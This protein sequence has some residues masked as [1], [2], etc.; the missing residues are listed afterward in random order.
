MTEEGGEGNTLKTV[1]GVSPPWGKNRA[2]EAMYHSIPGVGLR[3]YIA[4]AVVDAHGGTIGLDE[5]ST[6]GSVFSFSVPNN[7]SDEN[8]DES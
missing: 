5:R 6:G 8:H 3:L 1:V 7:D 4:K 2:E